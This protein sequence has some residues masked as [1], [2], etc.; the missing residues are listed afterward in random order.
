MLAPYAITLLGIS[1]MYMGLTGASAAELARSLSTGKKPGRT[2]GST[3]NQPRGIDADGNP[4]P[5]MMS[6]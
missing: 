4:L 1:L 6:K 2:L 5:S 3:S